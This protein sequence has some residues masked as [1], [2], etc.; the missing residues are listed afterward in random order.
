M[1][2]FIKNL[3]KKTKKEEPKEEVSQPQELKVAYIYPKTQMRK[4]TKKGPTPPPRDFKREYKDWIA[5][6]RAA[7][8]VR[9]Q[10]VA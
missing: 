9:A 5:N 1:W 6:C 7:D 4:P 2:N 8:A 3:F 10:M